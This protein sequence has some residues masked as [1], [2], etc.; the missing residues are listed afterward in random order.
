MKVI[1]GALLIS[2]WLTCHAA[3]G[4]GQ[5]TNIPAADNLS[6]VKN[7]LGFKGADS[8]IRIGAAIANLP[9]TGGTVDARGFEGPQTWN[10]CPFK[11]AALPLTLDLGAAT[12]SVTVDCTVPANVT[13]R[14]GEGSVISVASSK[15]LNISGSILGPI[16]RHFAGAGSVVINSNSVVEVY[17]QWWGVD[18]SGATSSSSA[19]QSAVDSLKSGGGTV[20]FIFAGRCRYNVS[21]TITVSSQKPINLLGDGFGSIYDPS[22]SGAIFPG[23]PINGSIIQYRSPNPNARATT[24]GGTISGLVFTDPLNRVSS[25]TAALELTDFPL[26]KVADNVFENLKGRAI[27]GEFLVMSEITGNIIRYCGDVGEPAI[28]LPSTVGGFVSESLKISGNRLEVN[29]GAPYLSLGKQSVAV[30]V[31][32]NRFEADTSVSDTSQPFISTPA[33]Y[34]NISGN[35][36]NRNANTVVILPGRSNNLTGNIFYNTANYP[37]TGIVVG[38]LST[39]TGNNF[40]T[41]RTGWEI[42]LQGSYNVVT[43]NAMYY[44]GGIHAAGNFNVV[45]GNSLVQ[46]QLSVG[47]VGNKDAFWIDSV[48]KGTSISGNVFDNVG[49]TVTNVGGIRLAGTGESVTGNTL[50][51]FYGSGNGRVGIR[52][53]VGSVTVVGNTLDHSPFSITDYGGSIANNV[54]QNGPEPPVIPLFATASFAPGLIRANS[55]SVAHNVIVTGAARGDFVEVQVNPLS[56]GLLI[57]NEVSAENTVTIYMLNTTAAPIDPGLITLSVKV[58]KPWN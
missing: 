47:T 45:S 50:R 10:T 54:I 42:D 14:F 4:F 23:N 41:T 18:C 3:R 37:T 52:V 2:L 1:S 43:G 48:G 29:H 11:D 38:S 13:V 30:N 36:F 19:I 33:D 12:F 55:V 57:Q 31:Y 34:L 26:S 46:G 9:R 39:I 44:S 5:G 21:S 20:K 6:R 51:D 40:G 32:D 49:G 28:D 16:S 8:A 58:R 25:V 35:Q 17:P 27:L 56:P 7:A 15:T 24:G 22:S 53:E